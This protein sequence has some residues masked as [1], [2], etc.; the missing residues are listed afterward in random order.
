MGTMVEEAVNVAGA[1]QPRVLIADDQPDMLEA[2]GLLLRNNGY[3]V[4][5]V[6]SP[7][8]ILDA[9]GGNQF[10]LLLMDLNYARD[11]TSGREGLDLLAR[12]DTLRD[13]PI[14]VMTGWG[15][16]EVA[17][18]AMQHGVGDFVQ[19]PWDN[20]R[21]LA[22]LRKQIELGRTLR[23]TRQEQAE[24]EL[25]A[26]QTMQELRLHEEEIQE[27]H[28]IQERLVPVDISQVPGYEIDAAWRPLRSV[29]GDYFD[30]LKFNEKSL[31]VCIG[32]V[33]G[34]GVPAALLMS[35]LQ[36]T[37]RDFA[38]PDVQ[39]ADLCARVNRAALPH[40][41]AD[42]F[43]TFFYG[44]LDAPARRL[45]Y[46]NAGHNPPFLV[47]QDGSC[48]RLRDGGPVLALVSNWDCRQG[49]VEL[50]PGDRLI[51]FTDG[52]TEATD[53]QGEEFQEERLIA[54][55]TA[56]RHLRP[57]VIREKIMAALREFTADKLND[58]ATLLV[59][60]VEGSAA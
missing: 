41:G 56:H 30:V 18:E 45:T 9:M 37:V 52:I 39:P 22:T 6:S 33:A 54:L 27:A 57:G 53:P 8:A 4:H 47:H 35:N 29:G 31:A 16:V 17:V 5:T 59:L 25:R 44:L 34:K 2:L 49:M 28:Q 21:L 13:M 12:L 46:V 40:V 51:L 48:R 42:R 23:R 26:Q 14:V 3:E 11:T 10:D 43:I 20:T 19:K 36:A 7:A 38:G 32:D 58:D 60:G 50:A 24:N 1:A 15:S 55:V